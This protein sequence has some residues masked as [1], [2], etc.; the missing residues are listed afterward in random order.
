[1]KKI[2]LFLFF[3]F[4]S[5]YV[6]AQSMEGF[7]LAAVKEGNVEKMD[8]YVYAGVKPTT[9]HLYEAIKA[10]QL[11]SVKFLVEKGKVNVNSSFQKGSRTGY[12]PI[13]ITEN[14]SVSIVEYLVQNGLKFIGTSL[15]DLLEVMMKKYDYTTIEKL[16]KGNYF[17]SSDVMRVATKL[18][19]QKGISIAS[20]NGAKVTYSSEALTEAC[21]RNDYATAKKAV[22][23]NTRVTA[24]AII[25]AVS[26]K[27]KELIKLLVLEG[28]GD[29]NG[30]EPRG[31]IITT[32][33]CEA[34]SRQGMEMVT[35][36]V[37]EMGV[38]PTG[39]CDDIGWQGAWQKVRAP[40]G[41]VD[42]IG[43]CKHDYFLFKFDDRQKRLMTEYLIL[44][45][46]I[47][48][49]KQEE[50]AN[51]EKEFATSWNTA[52]IAAT[53]KVKSKNYEEALTDLDKLFRFE[54]Y[55]LKDKISLRNK[56]N[57]QKLECYYRLERQEGA[58]ACLYVLDD[59]GGVDVSRDPSL[60]PILVDTYHKAGETNKSMI[61]LNRALEYAQT[62]EQKRDAYYYHAKYH[63]MINKSE[64]AAASFKNAVKYGF[65]NFKEVESNQDMAALRQTDIYKKLYKKYN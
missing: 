23:A 41:Y 39:M 60:V 33:M 29:I 25:N 20:Q 18:G 35:F 21:K 37:E 5:L 36:L 1:M 65:R 8:Q 40:K 6:S 58:L 26:H 7:F 53:A 48:K 59:E 31:M 11:S 15:D 64:I 61:F 2:T 22:D 51:K 16:L 19:N 3:S 28:G 34:I 17:K 43:S 10:K 30:R 24:Q 57:L 13:E 9:Y 32:P 45:P 52:F 47:Q 4:L 55:S 42:Y 44:A 38:S 62:N 50:I 27:N 12:I 56:V 46:S 49:R 54:N 63:S 14:Y